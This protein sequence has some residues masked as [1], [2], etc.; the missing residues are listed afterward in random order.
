MNFAVRMLHAI[1]WIMLG[2]AIFVLFIAVTLSSEAMSWLR[3]TYPV[4]N[5]PL[6]W[7]EHASPEFGLVHVLLFAVIAFLLRCLWRGARCWWPV[8][9]LAGLAAATELAQF[10]IPGRNPRLSD[11]RDDLLGAALGFGLATLVG[12]LIGSRARKAG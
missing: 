11:L 10:L 6:S 2:L 4:F 5:K 3:S 7:M 9:T 1:S 12:W 8:A